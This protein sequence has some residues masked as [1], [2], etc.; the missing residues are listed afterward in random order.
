MMTPRKKRWSA[1]PSWAVLGVLALVGGCGA[2]PDVLVDAARRSAKEQIDERID[3]W[4]DQLGDDLLE[5][6]DLP[7]LSPDD[8]E[9][10]RLIDEE[11]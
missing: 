6:V 8:L 11:S 5:S 3:M 1:A 9:D 10:E 7:S 4:L 2:V